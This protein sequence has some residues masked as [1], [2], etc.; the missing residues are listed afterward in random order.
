MFKSGKPVHP[1]GSI[2][3][4][5]DAAV[6]PAGTEISFD[7]GPNRNRQLTTAI[8]VSNLEGMGSGINLEISF[9]D[10]ADGKW[11]SIPP[12]VTI[13]LPVS[14]HRCRVRG[15]SGNTAAYSIMGVIA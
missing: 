14:I 11:F 6:T 1:T 4:A 15:V 13:T 12:E 5:P 7:G 10:G 9:A 8:M 2:G 3:V